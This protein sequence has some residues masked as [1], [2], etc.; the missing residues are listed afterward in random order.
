MMGTVSSMR[1]IGAKTIS[2][3]KLDYLFDWESDSIK[4]LLGKS[5]T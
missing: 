4:T 2:V 5:E 3:Y 1:K